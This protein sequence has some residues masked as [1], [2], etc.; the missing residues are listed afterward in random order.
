MILEWP[1]VENADT[2]TITIAK[3]GEIICTLIFDD[4][5][6]LISIAFAAP[7]RDSNGRNV[8]MA[9]QAEKGWR[10]EVKGLEAGA[11]YIY[12]ITAKKEDE[13]ILFTQSIDFTMPAPQGLNDV[14][15]GV[16]AHKFL[17]NGQ[18]FILRGNKTYTLTGAELK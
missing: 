18:I 13:S 17:R 9:E 1:A 6:Q 5:G 8:P 2:Y 10:Y 4:K 12:T 15:S 11:E 7:S 3:N 14:E 16:K